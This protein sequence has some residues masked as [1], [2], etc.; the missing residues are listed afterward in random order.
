MKSLDKDVRNR[1]T[2]KH[3]RTFLK[4]TFT[5]LKNLN[6]PYNN[7]NV[8]N[9]YAI[10]ASQLVVGSIVIIFW[11]YSVGLVAKTSLI[12]VGISVADIL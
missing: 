1:I 7:Y 10:S 5:R 6:Y 3:E 4:K 12:I 8:E 2:F 11:C 9:I